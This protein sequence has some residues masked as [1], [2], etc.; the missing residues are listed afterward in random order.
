MNNFKVIEGVE[1]ISDFIRFNGNG[2]DKTMDFLL[3]N[4]S[5]PDP[6]LKDMQSQLLL[7]LFKELK[8]FPNTNINQ[9]FN[10]TF[11]ALN[12]KESLIALVNRKEYPYLSDCLKQLFIDK[13]E[14]KFKG[15]LELSISLGIM[16]ND[17]SKAYERY[18][19]SNK[20]GLK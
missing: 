4:Y 20:V 8:H 9:L 16:L 7:S 19:F 6:I 13:E 2:I 12:N 17:F 3:E 14:I 15:R 5:S 10:K 18:T 11:E 1:G